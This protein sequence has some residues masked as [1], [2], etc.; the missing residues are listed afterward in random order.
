LT[1]GPEGAISCKAMEKNQKK[2][3]KKPSEN[4]VEKKDFE[5]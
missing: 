1:Q 4:R 3:L 2:I 5:G